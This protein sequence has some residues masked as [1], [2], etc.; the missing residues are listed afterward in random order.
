VKYRRW[1]VLFSAATGLAVLVSGWS[2]GGAVRDRG[3]TRYSRAAFITCI[4]HYR[5]RTPDMISHPIT[6]NDKALARV[7]RASSPDFFAARFPNGQLVAAAFAPDAAGAAHILS[8]VLRQVA[9]H[10]GAITRRVVQT[11][12]IVFVMSPHVAASVR[13]VITTCETAAAVK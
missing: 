4:R 2:T 12:N 6:A 5:V 9:K 13:T 7:L 3:A 8:Q 10:P 11:S 1:L